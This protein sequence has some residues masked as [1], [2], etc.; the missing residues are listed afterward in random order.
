MPAL[1]ISPRHA[2][3][4]Q[5]IGTLGASSPGRVNSFSDTPILI[6]SF[7]F[8]SWNAIREDAMPGK[9]TSPSPTQTRTKGSLHSSTARRA[10]AN[11]MRV[12]PTRT[13]LVDARGG[14]FRRDSAPAQHRGESVRKPV[15]RGVPARARCLAP[16]QRVAAFH[17]RP[18]QPLREIRSVRQPVREQSSQNPRRRVQQVLAQQRVRHS[19]RGPEPLQKRVRVLVVL[20]E[21]KRTTPGVEINQAWKSIS[22]LLSL[23]NVTNARAN[24]AAYTLAYSSVEFGFV[25]QSAPRG[26]P[27]IKDCCKPNITSS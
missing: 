4:N 25:A 19:G 22:C 9:Q 1:T 10:H 13:G 11:A 7:I 3:T 20:G 23:S 8:V 17:L 2:V 14:W 16:T 27:S 18:R 26:A 12:H 21:A 15:T 6:S 5:S 24:C